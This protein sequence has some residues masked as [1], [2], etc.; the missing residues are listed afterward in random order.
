M[1]KCSA[2]FYITL[3]FVFLWTTEVSTGSCN[4]GHDNLNLLRKKCNNT[5][6][7]Y[8]LTCYI[9]YKNPFVSFCE[10]KGDVSTS[11]T[12]YTQQ[13]RCSCVNV[14]QKNGIWTSD[15]FRVV[16]G[17]NVTAHVFASSG[18]LPW[19]TYKNFSGIPSDIML[20]GPHS[21]L[22]YKRSS[23][24]L[25]VQVEWGDGRE[26]IK[27]FF[28]EYKKFNTSCWKEQQS[29]NNTECVLWNLTTS[30]P[31][32]LRIRCV[33]TEKCVHCP[34]S[35][36]IVV[37]PELTGAPSIKLE[38]ED[39]IQNHFISQGQRK[40]VMKWEYA[41]SGSVSYYNVTVKKVSGEQ[42]N[43]DSFRTEDLS[44]TLILSY[45]AYNISIRAVNS[46]GSSSVSSITTEHINEW[47]DVFRPFGVN[48]TCNNSFSLYW[49]RSVSSVC[50]SVEWWAKGQIPNFC[51]FYE[52][53]THK[54]ITWKAERI[55]QPHTRYYF[56]LYTRPYLDTCNVKNV[57]N[58]E[59]TYGTAEAYFTE[60]SPVAAPGYVSILNITQHS[61][62][63]TWFPVS[64]E[65]LRG[66]LLGY[67]IY[68]TWEN[69]ETTFTVDSSSNSYELQNLE[70]NS[71]YRVQLSAF[72]AAGEGERSDFKH[73]DTHQLEFTALNSIIAAVI[74]GIIIL[75]LA[76][77]L[78]CR[79]LHRAK[80]LLWPSIPNPENSNAVQK[81][82]IAYELGIL[83]PLNRQRLEESEGCDPSTVCVFGKKM[84]AS[85]LC[86]PPTARV[87]VPATFLEDEHS[88]FI[89]EQTAPPDTPEQVPNNESDSKGTFSI[90]FKT[91]PPLNTSVDK[92]IT[93][94]ESKEPGE[95]I[96]NPTG[97]DFTPASQ[98]AVVFMSD[99]TTMEIFQQVTMAGIQGP[100][101][102]TV[103]PGLVPVHPGQDYVRQSYFSQE[104]VQ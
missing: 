23:G 18:Y 57:N 53:Q 42:C 92:E 73:F 47:K 50:F 49:N 98:P 8:D 1:C 6:G 97:S 71:A 61:S 22:T 38:I 103:K 81:I 75:L 74:V 14:N 70:S 44:L 56:V 90:D 86:S 7:V 77:H 10:W 60:G 99:Y 24:H 27:N 15:D 12:L 30:L 40:A 28:V 41:D 20:C 26:H 83:E 19:C 36:V 59:T 58:S 46:A 95:T 48:I 2:A 64:E 66:F 33:P 69:N 35:E 65:D 9:K 93:N 91:D 72:T 4:C 76:V 25:N 89:P 43:Q 13:R 79:L 37:P 62:V 32:D 3:G 17:W 101:I 45:S 54:E 78:S 31:Y 87:C 51:S 55:F 39:H 104:T 68:L 84:E 29:K 52:K 85:P 96:S 80:K 102:Q 21:K 34:R 88:P 5:E 16:S 94:F 100:S 67:Y 82:E 11:Y 63:I